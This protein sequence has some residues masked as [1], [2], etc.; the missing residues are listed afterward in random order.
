MRGLTTS[1]SSWKAAAYSLCGS[2]SRTR[3]ESVAFRMRSR[4]SATALDLPQPVVPSTAKCF[5][6]RSWTRSVASMDSSWLSVPIDDRLL[7]LIVVDRLQLRRI[8]LVHGGAD[9][10]I[11]ADA[12]VEVRLAAVR[13]PAGSRPAARRSPASCS[14][15]SGA[16]FG[17][18]DQPDDQGPAGFDRQQLADRE[19]V[20]VA[21]A[22]LFVVDGDDR[23]RAAD[24]DDMAERHC[25]SPRSRARTPPQTL[26]TAN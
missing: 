22:V 20:A 2:M 23:A 19:R 13:P 1:A 7:A 9:R 18:V 12:A 21:V 3:V 17:R 15:G 8:H 10:R 6:R 26:R 24:G 11:G 5:C 14:A 16:D 4:S 25:G